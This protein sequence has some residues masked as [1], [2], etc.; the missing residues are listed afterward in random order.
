MF[1]HDG[2]R[3]YLEECG[4]KKAVAMNCH[5]WARTAPPIPGQADPEYASR[6]DAQRVTAEF[7]TSTRSIDQGRKPITEAPLFGGEA[8]G[9]LFDE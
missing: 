7:A 5:D 6:I 2:Y 3:R 1:D 8:Q 9:S 4:R